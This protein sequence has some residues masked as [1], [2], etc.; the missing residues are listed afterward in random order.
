MK[1]IIMKFCHVSCYQGC[2]EE[3]VVNREHICIVCN[4]SYVVSITYHIYQHLCEKE[5][6][7]RVG[8]YDGAYTYT[9]ST[10]VTI[11]RVLYVISCKGTDGRLG[12]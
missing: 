10:T 6:L 9:Q 3:N 11:Q 4:T 5:L 7:L 1:T 12:K 2:Y 8:V